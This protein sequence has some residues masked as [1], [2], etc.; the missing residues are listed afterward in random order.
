MKDTG[1]DPLGA[2]QFRMVPSGDIV[3]RTER[4]RRLPPKTEP[5]PDGVFGLSWQ[6]VADKQGNPNSIKGAFNENEVC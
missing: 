2:G 3:D 5:L 1:S 6:Q 4:N